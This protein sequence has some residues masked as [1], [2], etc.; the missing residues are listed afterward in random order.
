MLEGPQVFGIGFHRQVARQQEVTGVTRTHL[1]H[2]PGPPQIGDI[3][4]QNH[5][6]HR[7]SDSPLKEVVEAARLLAGRFEPAEVDP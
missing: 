4:A 5:L 3:V 2:V 6:H 1:D 7:H